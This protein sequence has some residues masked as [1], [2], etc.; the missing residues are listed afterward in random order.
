MHPGHAS[1]TSPTYRNEN[2]STI[3]YNG[4]KLLAKC[5]AGLIGSSA[6]FLYND[7][8]TE[9]ILKT[10]LYIPVLRSSLVSRP[11][12]TDKL[13]AGTNDRLTVVSAPAG[14]GKTTLVSEWVNA[15][16]PNLSPSERP[17]GMLREGGKVCWLSLDESDNDP[18]R[19][20]DYLL[21]ALRQVQAD[22]G[23]S[24]EEMLHLPQPPPP[25]VILTA[26][27]NE[28]SSVPESFILVLDDYHVIHT[29]PIHRQLNFLLE[30]EPPQIRMVILTREDPPLSLSRLRA[31][32]QLTEIRQSD[33]RFSSEECAAFLHRVMGLDLSAEHVAVLERRTEGWIAG[34]QLAALSMRGHEDVSGFIQA[35]TGSSRFILDYLMEEVFERQAPDIRNFLLKTSVLDRMCGTLCDVVID[36]PSSVTGISENHLINEDRSLITCS[37]AI[38]ESLEHLNLFVVPLDQSRT[39]YRYHRLFQELLHHRLRL[40]GVDES[41]LHTRASE[42]HEAHGFL[43]EAVEHSLIA[44]DWARSARLVGMVSEAMLQRGES[45]TLLNW[46]GRLPQE[47]VYSNRQLCMVFIWA[48]LMA[49]RFDIAVPLLE[50]VEQTAEPNSYFL[51]EVASAQAFL[52]RAKRDNLKTIERSEQALA[53]L[54]DTEIE[55]RGVIAMNL[56]LAYWHEGQLAEAESVL[57]Q[58]C[59]LC[60][61]TENHYALLTAQ[62]FLVKVAA[63]RGQIHRAA[64]MAEQLIRVGGQTPILLLAHGDLAEIHLEWNNLQ[65]AWAHYEQVFA[66]SQRSGNMEFIQAAYLRR[67]TLAHALGDDADALSALA[68]AD[69][70]ARDFPAVI[71]G[72]VAAFGVHMALARGDLQMLAHWEP[73]VHPAVDVHSF[74]RFMGLTRPRL[75]MARGKKEE[76]AQA[77]KVIYETASSSGWGY[78]MIVIRILQSL[79]AKDMDE[80]I[81]FISE[82]LSGGEPEGFIRSFAD[83]GKDMIPIL[84]EAAKRGI[85]REYVKRVLAEMEDK[86]RSTRSGAGIM[87]DPLSERETEVL[88]L[89]MSGMSNR[90]IAAELFIS[91]GTAKTHIHHLCRKLGVR[92][93]TEAA[94][95]AKEL[96]LV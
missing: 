70:M 25:E 87:I 21:A 16:T 78:G 73:Q 62:L 2:L 93:R 41:G 11:R 20:L 58:A 23:Q 79:A 83:A 94:M 54:P 82:A 5:R 43:P 71:R 29:P 26:L 39:W 4:G 13:N 3:R 6:Y 66:L 14:Y 48:A 81:Q 96:N 61:K 12:L 17:K 10:K 89:V 35:F 33:L 59:D 32:G 84:H 63:S 60:S 69:R 49:S 40:S 68:V 77:L 55:I 88:R 90:E 24:V 22:V 51:G 8:M 30:H 15:L 64:E 75:L 57:L 19:F 28:L 92:N 1:W 56:G 46:Y 27:V 91:A 37:Q 95:R 31:R 47:V 38:L 76:A 52:A 45:I 7:S 18:R 42:W 50:H 36:G 9:T 72:R 85:A 67:A 74:Y 86:V 44:Q 34:L 65:K 53:L 80:A